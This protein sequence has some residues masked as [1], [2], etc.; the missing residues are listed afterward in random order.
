MF[1]INFSTWFTQF[2]ILCLIKDIFAPE[3]NIIKYDLQSTVELYKQS[4]MK[5]IQN[6]WNLIPF[7]VILE[8][9]YYYSDE[10]NYVKS[11]FQVYFEIY[12]SY[13]ISILISV[14]RTNNRPNNDLI[15]VFNI[16]NNSVFDIYVEYIL[17]WLFLPLTIGL[18]KLTIDIIFYLVLFY[19]CFK[20]SNLSIC[21][22][23]VEV[24]E[25]HLKLK[26]FRVEITR[27][28][29]LIEKKYSDFTSK[30]TIKILEK[31]Q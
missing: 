13:F 11:I 23:L 21:V 30:E 1:L 27:I 3:I 16:L 19:Y 9:L 14:Y 10:Y 26:E 12:F 24:C 20:N 4:T 8:I 22:N 7:F 29:G 17:P 31:E 15:C 5:N 28:F 2:S 18:N 25:S 6:F